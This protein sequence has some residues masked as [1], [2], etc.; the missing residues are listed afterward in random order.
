M[1]PREAYGPASAGSWRVGAAGR[2]RLNEIAA[3]KSADE[4]IAVSDELL[5]VDRLLVREPRLRRAL[6]DPARDSED[7]VGLLRSVLSGKIGDDALGLLEALVGGR[8]S[9]A[10]DLVDAVERLGVDAL[11][12]AGERADELADVEDELFRFGHVVDGSPDLA[13]TLGDPVAPVEERATLVEDLLASKARPVTVRLVRLALSGFGG[14]GFSASLGR[15]VELAAA[16]RERQVAYVTSAV[17]LTEQ[18]EARLGARLSEM[19]GR[20]VS[21]KITVDPRVIG[22]LSVQVGSDLYDGTVRRRLTDVR[23][24]LAK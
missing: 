16:R 19:Y 11:L 4:L 2:D 6:A 23:G 18:E 21:L 20:G 8:W 13:A 22:G 24:A 15:M 17:P 3:G 7:R 14:R 12:A 10:G 1:Q 5:S 9:H